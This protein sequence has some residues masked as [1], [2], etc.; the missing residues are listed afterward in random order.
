MSYHDITPETHAGRI[1]KAIYPSRYTRSLKA[2]RIRGAAALM[3]MLEHIGAN[4]ATDHD[5]AQVLCDNEL[6]L[7]EMLSF[8]MAQLTNPANEE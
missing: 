3:E 4:N 6:E 8:T 5:V 2:R 1:G 7:R